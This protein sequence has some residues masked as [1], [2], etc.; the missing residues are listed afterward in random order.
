[1]IVLRPKTNA[2]I[3]YAERDGRPMGETDLHRWWMIRIA[4]WLR[5]RYHGQRVYVSGN[6]LIY[7]EEGNIHRHVSPDCFVVFD[8]E[9]GFRRTY[10]LW[11]EGK[12]P[13]VVFE[14]TSLSTKREDE[15]DKP[16]LYTAMGVK[17][18][19]LY[20][21]T[22][23]YLEPPLQGYRYG[24]AGPTPIRRDK[25][26]ALVSRRLGLSLW[27]EGSNLVMADQ[28]TGARLLTQTEFEQAQRPAAEEQ[29]R[30]ARAQTKQERAKRKQ[31]EDQLRA[32][33]EEIA[34]LRRQLGQSPLTNKR[35]C[36]NP[37]AGREERA[38]KPS[39]PDFQKM[40]AGI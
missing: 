36:R 31:L 14:V 8:C 28:K 32:A 34:A 30:R 29:Q 2:E 26:G 18:G 11:E 20:D 13:D 5:W 10:K 39:R 9:P 24:K 19:F 16:A 4:D 35:F 1:L 6:L 27:L 22:A 21:P 33:Q 15:H 3:E 37:P 38:G 23:D 12:A 7:P 25:R 40:G 17:E